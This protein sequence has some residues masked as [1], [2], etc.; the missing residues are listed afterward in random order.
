MKTILKSYFTLLGL[1]CSVAGAF[2]GS[3]TF[4]VNMGTQISWGNFKPTTGTVTAR[5][6]F[7]G[8]TPGFA[9]TNSPGN[10][11]VYVGTTE[12]SGLVGSTVEYKF[13]FNNNDGGGDQWEL[14]V[15]TAGENRTFI[16][17]PSPQVL[18]VR[19][20]NDLAQGSPTVAVTFQVDMSVQTSL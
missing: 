14:P 18:P 2:A 6:S 4:Q 17:E 20:F 7:N 5:G 13:A 1:I 16:L 11:N 15:S 10:T 19:H 8:W 12:V 9:L 3:V